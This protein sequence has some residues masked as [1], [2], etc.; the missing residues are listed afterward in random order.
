MNKTKPETIIKTLRR[1]LSL[2]LTKLNPYKLIVLSIAYLFYPLTY[3]KKVR[4]DV[5][6]ILKLV[7][8]LFVNSATST[9]LALWYPLIFVAILSKVGAP[10]FMI[11]SIGSFIPMIIGIQVMPQLILTLKNSSILKRIGATETKTSDFTIA[12]VLYFSVVALFSVVMNIGLGIAFYGSSLDMSMVNWFQLFIS[13]VIGIL[14]ASSFGI[15]LSGILKSAQ[16]A[17][18]IGLLLTLPG[19]FLTSEFL[20]PSLINDWGPVRYIAFI[21]PQKIATVLTHLSTNGG[22]I[23]EFKDHFS[24]NYD[25][26]S[27]V[28]GYIDS[29]LVVLAR[30]NVALKDAFPPIDLVNKTE[31]II[32]WVLAPTFVFGFTALSI[33]YFKWGVR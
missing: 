10:Q 26:I 28:Q 9:F 20:P 8:H 21:F 18:V 1:N 16:T 14:I 24:S 29:K 31:M 22:S 15:F 19:A 17:Q 30:P 11:F 27:Q 4:E 23:F 33:K 25:G 32:T 6:P 13:I 5:L 2:T 3:I 7:N 12:F